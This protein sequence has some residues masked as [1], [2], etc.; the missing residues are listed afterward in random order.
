MT[1]T[2]PIRTL[3]FENGDADPSLE[4]LVTNGIGGYAS[5]PVR[6]SV[7]RRYHGLLI[8]SLPV[9]AGR[10]MCLNL[11]RVTAVDRA[12]TIVVD[13]ENLGPPDNPARSRLVEFT[14]ENGLPLWRYDLG[15]HVSLEKRVVMPYGRNTTHVVFRLEGPAP[16]TLRL[17]PAFQVRGHEQSVADDPPSPHSMKVNGQTVDQIGRAHV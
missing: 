8:A 11:L 5:G 3:R 9:P 13:H 12:R 1:A 10:L 4:W 15:E 17:E 7:T 14:L 6:G 16:I 2:R